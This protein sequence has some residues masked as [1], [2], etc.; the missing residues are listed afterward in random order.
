MIDEI[1]EWTGKPVD[2]CEGQCCW[3]GSTWDWRQGG[4]LIEPDVPKLPDE[5][6]EKARGEESLLG[7]PVRVTD[8]NLPADFY[9]KFGPPAYPELEDD[10]FPAKF[11][12]DG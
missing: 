10:L 6:P 12:V 9:I 2:L 4:Y 8:E 3:P 11:E 1:C 5:S 7:F